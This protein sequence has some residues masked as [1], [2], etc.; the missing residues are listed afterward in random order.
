MTDTVQNWDKT[1]KHIMHNPELY[2]ESQR[3]LAWCYYYEGKTGKPVRQSVVPVS[4]LRET[5]E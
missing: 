4:P 5:N 3:Y 2:S 1:V